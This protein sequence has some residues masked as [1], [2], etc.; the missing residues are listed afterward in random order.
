MKK[1]LLLMASSALLTFCLAS[2]AGALGI[3]VYGGFSY[4]DVEN[5]DIDSPSTTGNMLYYWGGAG[6]VID[7]A[8][9]KKQLFNYRLNLGIGQVVQQPPSGSYA[10]N[11]DG[12]RAELMSSFGFGIVKLSFMR[13]WLGPQLGLRFHHIEVNQINKDCLLFS[14]G[15]V[16]GFNFNIGS[17]FT[18]GIDGGFRYNAGLDFVT[19]ENSSWLLD[20]RTYFAHGPEGFVNVSIIFRIGDTYDGGK[21]QQSRESAPRETGAQKKTDKGKLSSEEDYWFGD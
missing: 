7:T 3:G 5:W 14:G 1:T 8:V 9:A 12:I 2:P 16:L 15:A 20:D 6:L 4:M 19:F 17:F 10:T 13:M 11:I 21:K 18:I